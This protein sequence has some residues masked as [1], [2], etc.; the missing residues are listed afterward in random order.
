MANGRPTLFVSVARGTDYAEKYRPFEDF[1]SQLSRAARVSM[2]MGGSGAAA[3]KALRSAAHSAAQGTSRGTESADIAS[4]YASMKVDVAAKVKPPPSPAGEG[5]TCLLD[6]PE[7]ICL[8]LL[9]LAGSPLLP[10]SA[11][12]LANCCK[13][14]RRMPTLRKA[15]I[16][17]KAHHKASRALSTKCGTTSIRMGSAECARLAW[18][19]KRLACADIKVLAGLGRFMPQL[20]ELDLRFNAIGDEG[21][22]A[23]ATASIKGWLPELTVLGLSNNSV[24]TGGAKALA[25]AAA[26]SAPAFVTLEQLSLSFNAIDDE[27]MGELALAMGD[28][29]LPKLVT[30]VLEGNQGSCEV[31]QQALMNPSEARLAAAKRAG[32]NAWEYVGGDSTNTLSSGCGYFGRCWLRQP[33]VAASVTDALN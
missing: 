4:W 18:N 13:A 1:G 6:L 17:F 5:S 9:M 12:G 24:T 23:L 14:M 33:G 27:G 2:A 15:L 30:F 3:A 21:L 7:D 10:M 29:A 28:G 16:S 26:G 31:V 19:A 20:S 11:V 25:S 22:M 8:T 32:G